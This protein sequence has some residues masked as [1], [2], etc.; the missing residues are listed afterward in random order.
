MVEADCKMKVNREGSFTAL[1]VYW[2][3]LN[4]FLYFIISI[5]PICVLTKIFIG[6]IILIA[7]TYLMLINKFIKNKIISIH[8]K[9]VI[10]E[11]WN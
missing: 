10:T 9:Y 6:I 5:L 8:I 3:T 1:A 2:A 7:L 4:G 11:Y